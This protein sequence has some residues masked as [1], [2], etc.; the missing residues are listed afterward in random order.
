[1]AMVRTLTNAI[2]TG[3]IAHAFILT[4]VRGVGKTTTARILARALNC[5][6]PDGKGGPT[7]TPCGQCEPCRA[8]AEDRHVDV[9]EMDAA[10]RTGVEDIR[11]LTDGVRYK[12]VA[13]RYKIY[14]IDEV[15]ML[16]RQAFNAL[17][18]TLEEPPPDVKFIFATTE[19][20]KVPVT[21]LSRCQRFSL[22][23]V[24][25]E[26]LEQHYAK[27]LDAEKVAA[28][29]A[30][31]ALV[32]R[33]ADGSVRDGLSLL[34]QAIALSA[35]ATISEASVR[36][37]LGIADKGLVF[38]L[39]ETVLKGDAAGALGR[40]GALYDGG[41]D[42]VLVM[43]DLLDLVHFLMRLKLT[44]NAGEGDPA[45]EG[46]RGRGQPLA[47][48]LSVP[49]LVRAWQMLLK[50]LAETQTAPSPLQAAEMVLVRLAYVADLPAPADVVKAL[51]DGAA[52]PAAGARPP[53]GTSTGSAAPS[54]LGGG[55]GVSGVRRSAVGE[56]EPAGVPRTARSPEPATALAPGV[57]PMPQSFAEVVALFDRKREA[58]LRSH[59]FANVHLVRFEPGRIEL[60]PTEG[61]PRDLANRLGKLLGDW[62]GERWVVS[63]SQ[64]EGEPT[65]R[66]QAAARDETLRHEAAAH[67]LVRAVL[68]AFPGARIE[69]VRD[70]RPDAPAPVDPDPSADDADEGES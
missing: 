67:P 61:A 46:E 45:V 30:A 62:T 17:L 8:I 59:L 49:V 50:G 11:E 18:K 69:A 39:L 57:E 3:R 1:E 24:P 63:I 6:G 68:D 32:A 2:A 64:N 35:G 42:P 27:V 56:S 60:R 53:A 36:D 58:L 65:L 21:V 31:V 41:A 16:S 55:A 47:A 66:E 20:Q 48:K 23:R 9:L 37:M 10:S 52:P 7:I 22:R 26:L 70:M 13:A 34:D 33:A 28:E 5:V 43:Q 14:I 38:D 19:I 51:T 40:L 25:A 44:P 15:H 29:A 12:P 54:M 4:G